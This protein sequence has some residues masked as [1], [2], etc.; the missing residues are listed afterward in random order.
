MNRKTLSIIA[1]VLVGVIVEGVIVLAWAQIIP[2][3]GCQN[4]NGQPYPWC[5]QP[6][7][8]AQV[9]I[10][11]DSYRVNT[12]TNATLNIVNTGTIQ[13]T[14]IA[15]YVKDPQGNQY[16]NPSWSGPTI[17]PQR[18]MPVNILIDGRYFTFQS[19]T[20]YTIT[21]IT[22]RNDQFIFPITA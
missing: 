5:P 11:V 15:Y 13:V 20:G 17:L 10:N 16:S 21:M 18:L 1:V 3:C 9:M 2:T 14:L 19:R 7:C 8:L 12:P 6:P 22:S 4:A